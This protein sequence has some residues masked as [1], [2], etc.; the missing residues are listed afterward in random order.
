MKIAC[1][2]VRRKLLIEM[3]RTLL[4]LQMGGGRGQIVNSARITNRRIANEVAAT[5]VPNC[6]GWEAE[7]DTYNLWAREL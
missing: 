2:R 1:V 5:S 6:H 3:D 4:Q 7:E